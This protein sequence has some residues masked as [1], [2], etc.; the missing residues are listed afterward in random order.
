MDTCY[1]PKH[2]PDQVIIENQAIDGFYFRIAQL[3]PIYEIASQ[4]Y[5]E[6]YQNSRLYIQKGT[7]HG[8]SEPYTEQAIQAAV[9][10]ILE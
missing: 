4:K 2:I 6:I 7:D 3:L 8:F 1:D 5:H 10:F 9:D